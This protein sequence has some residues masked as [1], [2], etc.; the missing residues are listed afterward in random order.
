MFWRK[1]TN[2]EDEYDE[3]YT[4]DVDRSG[5][6][7]RFK[8]LPHVLLLLFV[9]AIFCSIVGV[10][11]TPT[12]LEK[13]VTALAMPLG[14]LWLLLLVT[15]YF[16]LVNRNSWPAI[17]CFVC[18]LLLTVGGN[19]VF[20]AWYARTIEQPY[21]QQN[22][23]DGEPWDVIV[24]L[25]GGTATR[26]SGKPQVAEAGD[27][28]VQAAR[29]W[30]AGQ[31]KQIM[32]TGLQAFPSTTPDV[33]DLHP[34]EEAG[35]LLE[36]LGIEPSAIL[37][38]SGINTFKEMENLKKWAD[39]NPGKRI[40]ILTSAWHLSRAMRLAKA[41][42]IEADPIAAGFFSQPYTPGPAVVVPSEYN[43]MVSAMITK[44]YL[45]GLVSR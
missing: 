6:K 37:H 30:H 11:A 44:E 34:H 1:K 38:L 5:G 13:L 29:L 15:M 18:W 41:Q 20:T 26:L 23:T 4:R 25:G 3:Y 10:V 7:V 9:A 45:A 8:Y 28:V 39:Q 2:W 33:E 14:V 17:M 21:L 32:C 22:L 40:G 16:C 35:L 12:M 43:L 36:E 24:V 42:G 19:K 31:A 27:R